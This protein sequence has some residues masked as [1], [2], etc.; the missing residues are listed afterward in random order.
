MSECESEPGGPTP[1]F[2]QEQSEL[3]TNASVA[4][5]SIATDCKSVVLWATL[6]QIQ[7]GAQMNSAFGRFFICTPEQA[8]NFACVLDL[9]TGV[10][11]LCDRRGRAGAT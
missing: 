11:S 6:V 3:N 9:K 8:N 1:A 10:M 4:E 5:R 7:P 2:V